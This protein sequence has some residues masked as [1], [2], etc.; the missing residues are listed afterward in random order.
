MAQLLQANHLYQ[1]VFSRPLLLFPSDLVDDNLEIFSSTSLSQFSVHKSHYFQLLITKLRVMKELPAQI[2]TL[3]FENLSHPMIG[4]LSLDHPKCSFYST[5]H[6]KLVAATNRPLYSNEQMY[7]TE[8]LYTFATCLGKVLCEAL[9][10]LVLFSF[11]FIATLKFLQNLSFAD[12]VILIQAH[13]YMQAY[14]H[15][16][17]DTRVHI[18]NIRT[19]TGTLTYT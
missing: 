10:R 18:L 14:T 17:T 4:C 12:F 19:L 13:V 2:T 11:Y 1:R 8:L 6:D 3:H 16:R 9:I 5:S 15:A 7:E